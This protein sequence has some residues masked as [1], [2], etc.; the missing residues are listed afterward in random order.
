MPFI[1]YA[2]E[3]VGARRKAQ[4]VTRGIHHPIGSTF[5]LS[6]TTPATPFPYLTFRPD[7][8]P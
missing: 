8:M 2:R 7:G 3:I 4:A 5:W 6:I 1:G